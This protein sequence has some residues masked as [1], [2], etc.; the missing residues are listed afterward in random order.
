LQNCS[1]EEVLEESDHP[2]KIGRPRLDLDSCKPVSNH[3]R[4]NKDQRLGFYDMRS[5]DDHWIQSQR[6]RSKVLSRT[7]DRPINYEQRGS[8]DWNGIRP[9]NPSRPLGIGRRRGIVS[10]TRSLTAAPRPHGGVNAD[11]QRAR[12]HNDNPMS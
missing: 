2:I 5:V 1:V 8:S 9:T 4:W 3:V 12:P 6:L 7:P 10:P 11:E